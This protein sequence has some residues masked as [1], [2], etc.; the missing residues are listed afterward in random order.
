L[1]TPLGE[2]VLYYKYQNGNRDN[3][4]AALELVRQQKEAGDLVVTAN[5]ALGD[6]YLQ[7]KTIGLQGLDLS[8]IEGN[9]SRVW[10]VEDMNVEELFPQVHDWVE[11]NAQ[12]VANLDVH[13]RARNFKMRVYLYDPVESLSQNYQA[14]H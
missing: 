9:G 5:R 8:R 2:D 4:K 11:Q 7:E 3:W 12:L 1:V 14:I 10:F 13:V 6:Y